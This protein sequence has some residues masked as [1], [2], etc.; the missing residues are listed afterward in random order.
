MLLVGIFV[1]GLHSS[2]LISYL[3]CVLH[4]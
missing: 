3:P 4:G 2:Q 1:S